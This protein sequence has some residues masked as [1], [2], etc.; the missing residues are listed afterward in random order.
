MTAP[1][2]TPL[3]D[4]AG[5]A[6][7]LAVSERTIRRWIAAGTLPVRRLPSGTIR[8]AVSDLGSL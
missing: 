3:T 5:A 1:T 6:S 2:P 8:I 4:V 7:Y